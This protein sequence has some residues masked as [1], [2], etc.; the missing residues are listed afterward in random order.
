MG[1]SFV[2]TLDLDGLLALWIDRYAEMAETD[3][4]LMPLQP[5]YFL[6]AN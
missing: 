6:A 2:E 4:A 1:G 5:V 3:R